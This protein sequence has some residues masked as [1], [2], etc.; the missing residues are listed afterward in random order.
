VKNGIVLDVEHIRA[1]SRAENSKL[2]VT[3]KFDA[4]AIQRDVG[5]HI[6]ESH[7]N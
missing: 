4:L 3:Y 1:F 2:K 6:E 5:D 7:D